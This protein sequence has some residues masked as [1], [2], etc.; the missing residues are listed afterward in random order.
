MKALADLVIVEQL[1]RDHLE[2][3]DA[4]ERDLDRLVDDTHPPAADAR[5]DPVV[6]QARRRARALASAVYIRLRD[7]AQQIW[8]VGQVN[9]C[10]AA[11]DERARVG[12][13]IGDRA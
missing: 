3:D 6:G 8:T 10:P 5:H 4:V 13:A 9:W 2:R 11:P 7:D 1:G 12:A